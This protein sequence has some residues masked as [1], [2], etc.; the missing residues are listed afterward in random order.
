M[1]SLNHHICN[2]G[3]VKWSTP[4]LILSFRPLRPYFFVSSGSAAAAKHGVLTSSAAR[5]PPGSEAVEDD[6]KIIGEAGLKPLLVCHQGAVPWSGLWADRVIH[7]TLRNDPSTLQTQS[8]I[9]YQL[10]DGDGGSSTHLCTTPLLSAT[11]LTCTS[12]RTVAQGNRAEINLWLFFWSQ[13]LVMKTCVVKKEKTW[14]DWG[15]KDRKK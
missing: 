13:N 8:W 14:E 3:R 6:A 1:F 4:T 5:A 7:A 12:S 10:W 2:K 11:W 15:F 9:I